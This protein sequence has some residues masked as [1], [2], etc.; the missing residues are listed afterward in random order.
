MAEIT[1]HVFQLLQWKYAI[2]CEAR[3]MRHSS[4]R[5]VK[6]HAARMLGLRPSTPADVVIARI[7]EV[8]A[9]G[10]AVTP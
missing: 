5:S 2:R 10:K 9:A 1:L 6:A 3:G 4:G 8:L 7:E